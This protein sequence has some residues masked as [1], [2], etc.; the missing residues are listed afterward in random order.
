MLEDGA[1]HRADKG[2]SQICGTAREFQDTEFTIDWDLRE[3][4]ERGTVRGLLEEGQR[5]QPG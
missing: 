3:L 4:V 5:K 2:E 1:I